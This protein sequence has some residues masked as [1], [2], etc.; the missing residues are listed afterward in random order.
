MLFLVILTHF[1]RHDDSSDRPNPTLRKLA[2][3][4]CRRRGPKL[5]EEELAEAAEN[6]CN[7]LKIVWRQHQRLKAEGKLD[8]SM[9]LVRRDALIAA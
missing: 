1:S 5:S 2:L 6:F 7:Y 9:A 4:F 3:G 8:E